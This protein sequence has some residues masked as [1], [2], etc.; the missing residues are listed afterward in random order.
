[1]LKRDWPGNFQRTIRDEQGLELGVMHFVPGEP[2]EVEGDQLDGIR[3]DIG[4]ALQWCQLT[5]D[6][7][8]LGKPHDDQSK[9]PTPPPA[10][11]EVEGDEAKHGRHRKHK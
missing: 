6:G 8:G 4:P 5:P 3:K 11:V 7:H 1:M 9:Q 2:V 10:P